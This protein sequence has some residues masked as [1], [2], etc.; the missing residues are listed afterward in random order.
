[1]KEEETKKK[2]TVTRKKTSSEK[3]AS[4]K[5]TTA[6]T[7]I[8]KKIEEKEKEVKKVTRKKPIKKET[9][10]SEDIEIV[11]KSVEFSLMEVIV[12]VLITG[13]VVSVASGIIVYNNYDKLNLSSVSN[14]A[15]LDEFYE[16][17]NKIVNKYVE[18]VNKE[19]LIDAAIAG[20]YNYLGDEYSMYLTEE[21]TNDLSEQL[22]GEYTGIGIEI[23]TIFEEDTQKQYVKI[24]RVFKD[25]P[26]E[27]AG[28]MAGDI[29]TKVDGVEMLDAN[30]VSQTIKN[31]NKE[32]YEVTYIRDGKENTLILTRK[33][34]LI[35]SVS[36]EVYDNVGYVKIET[37]SAT[38]RSQLTNILDSFDKNVTSLIID[39]RNNTGGYLDT[40]YTV[41]DLFLEKGKIVYE[42][43]DRN[44]KITEYKAKEGVYRKFDKIVVLINENSASASEILTLALKESAGATV[45]GQTSFGKGTVQET[46][47]LNSG[48]MI[49]YTISYWLSPKGNSIN[50]VGIEPDIKVVEAEKQLDEA[51][52]AA[53]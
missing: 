38:T 14:N 29:I 3:E 30:Q 9:K 27:A 11:K 52:K 22:S 16:N 47:T 45:V 40:A 13:L 33:R 10:K 6:E 32:S 19:E 44:G 35:N 53:K 8:K 4:A 1:M 2:K 34:V 50:K 23:T 48:S 36:S 41:S 7:T 28:L 17:Y 26:A 25:S 42:L 15:E 39:L 49:K 46:G 18:E 51:I 37:F 20:M 31:G 24:N 5:K 12:I 21:E 43:K